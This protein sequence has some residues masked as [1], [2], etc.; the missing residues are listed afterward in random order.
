MGGQLRWAL[1]LSGNPPLCVLMFSQLYCCIVDN[2]PS[3]SLP[4]PWRSL[5]VLSWQPVF[6]AQFENSWLPVFV[7]IRDCSKLLKF[8]KI[9]RPLPGCVCIDSFCCRFNR[10]YNNN[11]NNLYSP[12][13]QKQWS[14]SSAWAV[15]HSESDN[16]GWLVG[17]LVGSSLTSLFTDNDDDTRYTT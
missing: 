8:V 2:K 5:P 3:L 15:T 1:C 6:T 17:W 4:K 10:S 14:V 11:N 12:S 9:R 16:N 7:K 13:M